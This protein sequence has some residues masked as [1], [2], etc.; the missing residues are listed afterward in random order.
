MCIRIGFVVLGSMFVIG[1]WL[2]RKNYDYADS[3]VH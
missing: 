2:I 3:T 1:S